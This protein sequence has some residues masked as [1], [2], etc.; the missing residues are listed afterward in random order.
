MRARLLTRGNIWEIK[1]SACNANGASHDFIVQRQP[2]TIALLL[3]LLTGG[4]ATDALWN[5]T[6]LDA[7]NEPAPNTDVHLFDARHKKDFLVVYNEYSERHDSVR[8]RAYFLNRNQD[9]VAQGRKPHFVSTRYSRDLAPVQTF[10]T[11]TEANRNFPQTI[12]AVISSN[13]QSFTIYSG[14]VKTDH[15]LAVY[16]DGRGRIDRIALTPVAVTADLTIVG[17]FLGCCFLYEL[18]ESGYSVSVH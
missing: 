9:R 1:H 7:W 16:N 18:A 14:D 13:R 5:K 10:Q 2:L 12:Y 3:T 11:A 4:C 8:P 15:S 17:G 6:D